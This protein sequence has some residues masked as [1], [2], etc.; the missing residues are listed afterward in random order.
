[1]DVRRVRVRVLERLVGMDVGVH[2]DL[3]ALLVRVE[4][5][6]VVPVPVGVRPMSGAAPAPEPTPG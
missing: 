3:P 2:R 1:M 4:V 6:D 5:V